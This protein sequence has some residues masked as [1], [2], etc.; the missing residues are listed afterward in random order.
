MP[1]DTSLKAVCAPLEG[2][3]GTLVYSRRE[4]LKLGLASGLFAAGCSSLYSN[5]GY[6]KPHFV[7]PDS[8]PMNEAMNYQRNKA[9]KLSSRCD[10]HIVYKK[11]NREDPNENPVVTRLS[12][13]NGGVERN[14]KLIKRLSQFYTH[15]TKIYNMSP[16]RFLNKL[17]IDENMDG[18]LWY[19]PDHIKLGFEC[20]GPDITDCEELNNPQTG[21]SE[22]YLDAHELAHLISSVNIPSIAGEFQE[23]SWDGDKQ[24]TDAKPED[25]IS[26]YASRLPEEDFAEMASIS[27]AFGS[28]TRSKLAASPKLRKKYTIIRDNLLG[29]EWEA[30]D[31]Q[32]IEREA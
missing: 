3:T 24:K 20:R 19:S 2:D 18:G 1:K 29:K 27:V 32:N 8:L 26:K 16:L 22:L 17:T 7:H 15:G 5:D 30:K 28:W 21:Q 10:I 12:S 14:T 23:I 25:F 6:G 11:I 9:S 31:V 4:I 13:Y